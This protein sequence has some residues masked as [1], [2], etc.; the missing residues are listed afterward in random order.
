MYLCADL[1]EE[2]SKAKYEALLPP[3]RVDPC[4]K[5]TLRCF[6]QGLKKK[7][8]Q[9]SSWAAGEMKDTGIEKKKKRKKLK[10]PA[11]SCVLC[12]F[13]GNRPSLMLSPALALWRVG[14]PCC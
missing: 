10:L 5:S 6:V 11:Q 9:S 13:L 8:L 3:T 12:G 7:E 4:C 14:S 1:C 2:N